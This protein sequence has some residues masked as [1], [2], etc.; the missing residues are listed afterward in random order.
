MP[1]TFINTSGI[2]IA[3]IVTLCVLVFVWELA[4]KL[5]NYV[6]KYKL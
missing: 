4:F 6:F 3:N 1:L 5:W 2:D